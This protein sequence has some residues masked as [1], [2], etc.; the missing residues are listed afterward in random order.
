MSETWWKVEQGGNELETD[1]DGQEEGWVWYSQ[2]PVRV[3]EFICFLDVREQNV[4]FR[5]SADHPGVDHKTQR[6]MQK[7]DVRARCV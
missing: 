7:V 5:D 6:F 4:T 3:R 1:Y 2:D